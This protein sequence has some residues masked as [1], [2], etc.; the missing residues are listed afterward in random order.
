MT[1]A[2]G[3]NVG[4]ERSRAELQYILERFG[5][6]QFGYA[7]DRTTFQARIMFR[8]KG[9]NFAFS[10]PL[11]TPNDRR[12]KFTPSGKL[13]NGTQVAANMQDE[14]RRRWRSLCLTVK[15]ML[16]GVED[17]IFNF[18]EIFMPYMIWGDGRTTAQTLLPIVESDIKSGNGLRMLSTS[19]LLESK[20]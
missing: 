12:V 17:G 9:A 14:N 11:A 3:T 19:N 18:A 10:M 13:R 2:A 4:E 1:Y 5:A 20:P 16:V 7:S 6:D 15:A 8:F